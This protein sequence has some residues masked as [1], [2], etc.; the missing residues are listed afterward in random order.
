MSD[1]RLRKL[2][3]SYE[4]EPTLSTYVPYL[5]E[6]I[7]QEGRWPIYKSSIYLEHLSDALADALRPYWAS[8]EEG[9]RYAVNHW[10]QIGDYR[11]TLEKTIFSLDYN[12]AL[13]IRLYRG[14][15]RAIMSLDVKPW[16]LSWNLWAPIPESDS[17]DVFFEWSKFS[18]EVPYTSADAVISYMIDVVGPRVEEFAMSDDYKWRYKW[19]R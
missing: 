18:K 4:S 3:R 8:S 15:Y 7:R 13:Y 9:G 16:G 19:R 12:W 10:Y 6:K 5:R 1:V 11:V 14:D 17:G 2:Q